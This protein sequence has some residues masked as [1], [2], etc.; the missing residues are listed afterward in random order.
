MKDSEMFEHQAAIESWE[1]HATNF[2]ILNNQLCFIQPY[3]FT[4]GVCYGAD[5]FSI[6][7]RF[8]FDSL[9]SA[10]SFIREW[11]GVTLPTIGQEGCTAIK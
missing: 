11:D 7:G 1:P 8:C 5:E 3:M 9:L 6:K 4:W 10:L 2:R